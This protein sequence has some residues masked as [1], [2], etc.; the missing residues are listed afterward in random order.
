M[1]FA[2][3]VLT[4]VIVGQ[5]DH[6]I[7]EIDITGPKEVLVLLVLTAKLLQAGRCSPCGPRAATS[8]VS[9]PVRPARGPRCGR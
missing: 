7:Y 6:P 8:P 9:A 4:F 2:Q 1:A 3:G 5:H